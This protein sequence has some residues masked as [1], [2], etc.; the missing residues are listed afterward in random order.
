M[1]IWITTAGL[2]VASL[3]SAC[4]GQARPV[5]LESRVSLHCAVIESVSLVDSELTINAGEKPTPGYGIEIVSQTRDRDRIAVAYRLST[6]AAG[7]ILPQMMTSPCRQIQLPDDWE[8]LN[9]TNEDS[10]QTWVFEH[11]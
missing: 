6:P 8:R 1:K 7:A 3:L 11:P 2:M 9:V 4:A 10:G 5:E